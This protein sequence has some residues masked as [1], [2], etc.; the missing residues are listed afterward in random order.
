MLLHRQIGTTQRRTENSKL[1][2]PD[3]LREKQSYEHM[4]LSIWGCKVQ[5]TQVTKKSTQD[6]KPVTTCWHEHCKY[7]LCVSESVAHRLNL[8]YIVKTAN[9]VKQ[10]Q[11]KYNCQNKKVHAT[12]HT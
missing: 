4:Q 1:R 9:N 12:W 11:D 5:M 7:V 6:I 10:K 3:H 8:I 2:K